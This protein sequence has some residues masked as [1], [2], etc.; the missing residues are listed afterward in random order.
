M[1]TI[2]I[3]TELEHIRGLCI[4]REAL[5]LRGAS[6]LE[7]RQCDRTIDSARERLA[8]AARRAA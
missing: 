1:D 5:R 8:T 7:L 6:A 2:E 3:D 4:I